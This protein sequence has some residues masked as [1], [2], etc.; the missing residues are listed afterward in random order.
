M[1][2]LRETVEDQYEAESCV[3]DRCRDCGTKSHAL[4]DARCPRCN[5]EDVDEDERRTARQA[6][7]GLHRR[8]ALRYPWDREWFLAQAERLEREP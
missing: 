4:E 5:G 8:A 2:F 7:A 1:A 3:R 6:M